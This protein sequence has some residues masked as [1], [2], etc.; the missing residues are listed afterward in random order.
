M[1]AAR[2]QRGITGLETA[3]ILIAFV[4]VASVFAYV[5]LSAGLFS[6]QKA[7]EA[8]YAG[9]EETRSTIEIKGD[10]IAKMDNGVVNTVYF[11]VGG[12]PGNE[13]VDFTDTSAGNNKVII[14]FSDQF[15]QI[16]TVNWTLTKLNSANEDNLLDATEMF[17]I[18][19]DLSAADNL[20]AYHT[21][22][23][24]LKPPIGAVMPLERTIPARVSQYINL[25]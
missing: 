9:L 18:T 13:P 16:P 10:A 1:A 19:V 25:H 22:T 6:A 17:L 23:L 11:T 4:I 7:K 12:R 2:G 24:E 3:I 21:F 15:Q 5:V 14:S 20:S 8:V